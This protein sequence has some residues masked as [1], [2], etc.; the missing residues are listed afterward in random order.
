M[1]TQYLLNVPIK[2]IESKFYSVPADFENFF[3]SVHSVYLRNST[4][5]S[6][7][8]GRLLEHTFSNFLNFYP[9]LP[10]YF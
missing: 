1:A 4:A 5:Q 7:S 8:V 3:S 2:F 9:F 6:I 10:K